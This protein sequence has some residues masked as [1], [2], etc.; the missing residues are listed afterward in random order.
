MDSSKKIASLSTEARNKN[1][2]N[3]DT[4]E[5]EQIVSLINEEDKKVALSISKV[6][7]E[8]S[9]LIDS[10]YDSIKEGGRLVYIGAGTSGR[11]GVL[12]AS[13]M[14]PTYGVDD[15]VIIGIIAGGDNALR[16]PVESAEDNA[17]QAI[18]DLKEINFSSTDFLIGIAASGRTP[19]V[20]SAIEYAKKIGSKTGSI[21]TTEN[22]LVG[23]IS[24]F[25][26]EAVTGPEP[27][28]GSTR[29]KSGT[30]QKMI[31]NIISTT[32][33]IKMGKVYQNYMVDLKITNEKLRLRAINIISDITGCN[34]EDAKQKLDE[35]NNSVKVAI[36]MIKANIGRE[37]SEKI[38]KDSNLSDIIKKLNTK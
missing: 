12:D 28:S 15:N 4:L 17:A 35:S 23:K 1:T 3:I 14:P 21:S 38:L 24:D 19:Y 22:S 18:K 20:C 16:N 30:A 32:L 34:I 26:I 10:A 8:I 2:I 7:N 27:I 5:T 13:E 9:L 6:S 33:M 37:E 11:L 31:L 29:M 36:L 25:P